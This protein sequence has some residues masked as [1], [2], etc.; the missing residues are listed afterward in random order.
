MRLRI[1]NSSVKICSLLKISV[2]SGSENQNL[3]KNPC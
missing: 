2:I 1:Q 3:A